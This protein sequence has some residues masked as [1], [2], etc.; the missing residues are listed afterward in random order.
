MVKY[1]IFQRIGLIRNI[2]RL[3]RFKKGAA[4]LTASTGGVPALAGPA[5]KG[6]LG[7]VG[8]VV[9]PI[10]RYL[11]SE[12]AGHLEGLVFA[13]QLD[14]GNDKALVLAQEAIDLEEVAAYRHLVADLID[15]PGL[16]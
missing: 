3:G 15:N 6:I 8:V 12:P 1:F 4:N 16:A 10:A 7:D 11:G 13:L 2:L 5:T 14:L 9:A